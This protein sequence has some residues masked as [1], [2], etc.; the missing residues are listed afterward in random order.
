MRKP[1]GIRQIAAI[2]GL[3]GAWH[4]AVLGAASTQ[5]AIL[6]VTVHADPAGPKIDRNL[7]GQ[8]AEHLGRGIYEG[9]WVGEDSP[10]PN[11][12]GYRNDVLAALKHIHVPVIRWPGGCFADDYNWRDGIG[13][14]SQ[15]PVR[16]NAIWG[17]VTESN[18]FGTHEFLEFAELVGA[19]SYLSIPVGAGSPLAMEQW[20]EYMLSSSQSTL[21]QERRRNGREQPFRVDYLGIGN[22]SWGCGGQM[23]PAHYVDEFRDYTAF[24]RAPGGQMPKIVASGAADDNYRWTEVLMADPVVTQQPLWGHSTEAISLHYYSTPGDD[25][26]HKGPATGFPEEQWIGTLAKALHMD[27]LI[28]KH[29]AIMDKYDPARR[30]ALYVDEWGAW[31]DQEP[32]STPGFLYQQ[33]SLRDA[34]VAALTLNIFHAHAERVRMANIAQMIN[35]LQAMI[36]TDKDRMILTPTYHVFD[37][38]QVFQDATRL[39]LELEPGSYVLGKLVVPQLSAT[40]ARG[41]DGVVHIGLANLDPHRGATLDI[42]L[43]GLVARSVGGRILTAATM[44]A[45]DGFE[46]P[47]ALEPTAFSGA[48]LH[49]AHLA[50]ELPAK[51]VVVLDLH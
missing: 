17:G 23:L 40:A 21:A 14:R 37:M 3:L 43:S 9:I 31:Y 27:E 33:N 50:V 38:Y 16:V 34:L 22:E 5:P 32:G 20:L 6:H 1:A 19:R 35:V 29:S 13:P 2:A 4:G 46:S 15:R 8:F 41:T 42:A 36:L 47:H 48:T 11:T 51:S 24:V 25:W 45:H 18:A 12:R 10:I 26:D 7:Y 39:P 30:I 28:T 49:G 44:D